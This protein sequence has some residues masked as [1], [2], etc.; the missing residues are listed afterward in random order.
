MTTPPKK[1]I[2]SNRFKKDLKLVAKQGKDL[3]KLFEVVAK[4]AKNLPLDKKF[5]PHS[6][7]G[8]WS[9]YYECH[10]QPDWLLIYQDRHDCVIL[11]RTGSHSRLLKK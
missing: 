2:Q 10:I 7:S 9:G 11:Y 4:L 3:E 1:I 6:L 8:N 5:K